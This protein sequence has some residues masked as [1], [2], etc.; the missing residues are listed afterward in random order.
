MKRNMSGGLI[1]VIVGIFLLT[2][3]GANY[4]SYLGMKSDIQ[5]APCK[6]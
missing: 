2:I 1:I 6:G 4:L 5:V 3:S